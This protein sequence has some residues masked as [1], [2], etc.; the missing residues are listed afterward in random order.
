MT[1]GQDDD[2][3]AERMR[4]GEHA[5]FAMLTTRHWTAVHRIARNMLPDQSKAREVAEETFLRAFRSPAWFPRDAPF[6]V[7]LYRLAIVLAIVFVSTVSAVAALGDAAHV[8]RDLTTVARRVDA[9]KGQS[10]RQPE[11]CDE[12]SE[13]ISRLDKRFA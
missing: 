3:L 9:A 7:S 2:V 11:R 13:K 8:N 10:C 1:N 5:A 12:T 6:K 4:R